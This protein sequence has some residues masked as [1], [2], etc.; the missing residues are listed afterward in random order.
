VVLATGWVT[1]WLVPGLLGALVASVAW[2]G[3][4]WYSSEHVPRLQSVPLFESLPPHQIRSLAMVARRIEVPPGEAIVRQGDYDDAFYLLSNGE[5]RVVVGE[6]V[7]ALLKP[8]G[9]FGEMAAIDNSARSA[10][11]VAQTPVVLL[12]LPSSALVRVIDGDAGVRQVLAM[13]LRRRLGLEGAGASEGEQRDVTRQ[14]IVD[15]CRRLRDLQ[16]P[17]WGQ[18][19]PPVRRHRLFRVT[20]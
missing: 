17:D 16:T 20:R 6:E 13:E 11:I 4:R 12:Q 14:D 7:K 10:S 1:G 5:A 8:G 2:I 3:I 15:L 9:Y 18:A 19:E